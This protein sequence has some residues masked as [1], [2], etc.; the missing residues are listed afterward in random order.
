GLRSQSIEKI[1]DTM[2]ARILFKGDLIDSK[3]QETPSLFDQKVAQVLREVAKTFGQDAQTLCKEAFDE[4]IPVD[5]VREML[6]AEHI[7]SADALYRICRALDISPSKPL[8]RA[9]ELVEQE[10]L[11]A[12]TDRDI[13]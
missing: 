2:G 4:T 3:K 7:I 10:R 8:E 5:K 11:G 6:N 9:A 12:I 1:L 13:A